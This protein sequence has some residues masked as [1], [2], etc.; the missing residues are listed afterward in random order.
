VDAAPFVLAGL[1]AYIV[2]PAIDWAS[3]RSRLP[4][5]LFVLLTFSL[6]LLF[7]ILIGYLGIPPLAR[8]MTRVFPAVLCAPR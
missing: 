3:A 7:A 2:T 1:L 8:E 4:R 6:F 5:V